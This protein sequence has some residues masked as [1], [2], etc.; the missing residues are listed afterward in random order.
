MADFGDQPLTDRFPHAPGSEPDRYALALV[1]CESCGLVALKEAPPVQALTP[2]VDWIVHRE[3]EAHLDALADRLM[4][5]EGLRPGSRALGLGDDAPPL[6][7]RLAQRGLRVAT[8]D[9]RQQLGPVGPLAGTETLQ[10]MLTPGAA[11]RIAA[12]HGRADLVVARSLVEHAHDVMLLLE[13]IAELTGPDGH[14]LVE[15][16]D[17]EPALERFDPSVLW[18]QHTSYFTDATLRGTLAR[19]GFTPIWSARPQG[20]TELD[21]VAKR[22]GTT[23]ERPPLADVEV[24]RALRF[25]A[26][27]EE[28][29][30]LWTRLLD[31]ERRAARTVALFGAGHVGITFV[32][33]FALCE[34]VS[35]AIDDDP[36]KQGLLL[37]GSE[38]P[39]LPS[40]RLGGIDTCLL[41]V[42]PEV[43]EHVT[44]SLRWWSKDGGRFLSIFPG[45]A[46]YPIPA[47]AQ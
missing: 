29:R 6:L 28:Q 13:A 37:P 43:E 31:Q 11:R 41:A 26:G 45:S 9:W 38:L 35:C 32:N 10:A 16:P 21:V 19:A 8:V 42:S 4:G 5:L 7:D 40:M 34:L 47:A 22:T 46:R 27:L 17:S 18:E 23:S 2:R 39:I 14:L 3:P 30:R 24:H 20:T 12:R 15:T 25:G 1:V 33:V 44:A 36:S